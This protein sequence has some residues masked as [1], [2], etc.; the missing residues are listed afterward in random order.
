MNFTVAKFKLQ[1]FWQQKDR[2][3]A[4]KAFRDV[5]KTTSNPSWTGLSFSFLFLKQ[6]QDMSLLEDC[7]SSELFISQDRENEN[8]ALGLPQTLR[9]GTV[10]SPAGQESMNTSLSA[11]C[12]N[13]QHCK[14]FWTEKCKATSCSSAPW[15]ASVRC[16]LYLSSSSKDSVTKQMSRHRG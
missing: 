7:P 1:P 9:V 5:F 3:E 14:H 8:G 2:R 16:Q 11:L 15:H 10:I 6:R 13:I 12:E 4:L